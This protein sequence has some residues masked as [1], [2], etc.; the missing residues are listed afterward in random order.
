LPHNGG[1]LISIAHC[2]DMTPA[3]ACVT[4]RVKSGLASVYE[5]TT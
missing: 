1:A 4:C 3:D 5:F 2:P